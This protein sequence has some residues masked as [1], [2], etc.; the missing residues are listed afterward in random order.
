MVNKE[1]RNLFIYIFI[2][3]EGQVPFA[4]IFIYISFCVFY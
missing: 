3:S 2:D 4:Y 1:K